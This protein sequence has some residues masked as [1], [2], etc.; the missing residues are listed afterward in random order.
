MT[1]TREKPWMCTTCG[2]VM[3]A[4]TGVERNTVPKDGDVT[5]CLKC[6][7]VYERR[8]GAW[9]PATTADVVDVAD[10]RPPAD[11]APYGSYHDIAAPGTRSRSEPPCGGG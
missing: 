3:D 8:A 5:L 10:R 6:A 4:A 1:T 2:Y 9:A 7:A 11:R